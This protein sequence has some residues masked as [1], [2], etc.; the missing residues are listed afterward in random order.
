MLFQEYLGE[1]N[2]RICSC[3][4]FLSYFVDEM[5]MVVPLSEETSPSLENS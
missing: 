3:G 4:V 1:K 5:F 2:S